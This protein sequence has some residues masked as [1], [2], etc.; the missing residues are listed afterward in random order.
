MKKKKMQNAT[1]LS[2]LFSSIFSRC[3]LSARF[4]LT[5]LSYL[6]A[7]LA[8]GVTEV[9]QTKLEDREQDQAEKRS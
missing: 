9:A 6:L 1:L 2:A 5:F 3:F 4:G 8:S 7:F